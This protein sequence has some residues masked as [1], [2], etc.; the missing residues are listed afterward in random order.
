MSHEHPIVPRMGSGLRISKAV[1]LVALLFSIVGSGCQ[2]LPQ[3]TAKA[4]S[5]S[6]SEGSPQAVAVETS[7]AETGSLQ[8]ITEYTGTTQPF[9]QVSLRARSEGRLMNLTVD[10]GDSVRQGQ[11]VAQLD[12]QLLRTQVNE[13]QT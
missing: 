7:R 6:Q 8:E 2:L 9:R 13:A 11:L 1:P 10:V 5:E 4:Q 3:D 12:D